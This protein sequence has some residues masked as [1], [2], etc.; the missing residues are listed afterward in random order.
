MCPTP[1]QAAASVA[2]S[3]TRPWA[4]LSPP[5]AVIAANASA[6]VVPRTS[7]LCVFLVQGC[8]SSK[9]H[10]SATLRRQ[11]AATK[12]SAFSAVITARRSTCRLELAL[13]LS[14]F[15]FALWTTRVGQA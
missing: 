2:Q 8:A 5:F 4:N 15:A 12:S 7:P 14:D 1:E 11:T 9:A 13:T 3:A 6:R 10:Q